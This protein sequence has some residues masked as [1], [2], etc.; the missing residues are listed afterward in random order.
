[1]S[2]GDYSSEFGGILT[3]AYKWTDPKLIDYYTI[4]I[5][6]VD[7]SIFCVTHDINFSEFIKKDIFYIVKELNI[8]GFKGF[9][10]WMFN[11]WTQNT[12]IHF[13]HVE[14]NRDNILP[15]IYRKLIL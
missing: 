13:C 3:V 5:H 15:D 9:N 7:L 14:I 8:R 1:M 10:D 4:L 6:K 11:D 12:S 2:I